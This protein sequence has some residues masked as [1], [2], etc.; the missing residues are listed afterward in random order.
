MSASAR[1]V[2]AALLATL[3]WGCSSTLRL[4][5]PELDLFQIAAEEHGGLSAAATTGA[6]GGVL[7]DPDADFGAYDAILVSPTDLGYRKT[8]SGNRV[9]PRL[10]AS[11]RQQ[12]PRT[13]AQALTAEGD[14]ALAS[15]PGPGVLLV[16]SGLV[17]I[18]LRTPIV[19]PA[20][21]DQAVAPAPWDLVVVFELRDS[22]TA[23]VV[24]WSSARRR[25]RNEPRR[26]DEFAFFSDMRDIVA[27][28]AREL[29][30]QLRQLRPPSDTDPADPSG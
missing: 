16:R 2:V 4:A 8:M 11:L 26:L 20:G 18:L 24:Y 22:V 6:F 15:E 19:D 14:F 28:A 27:F 1:S 3:L 13:I 29:R 12:L 7:V 25:A 23:D 30:R 17:R 21:S 5:R 10:E 9:P